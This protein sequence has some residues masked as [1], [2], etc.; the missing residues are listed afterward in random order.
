MNFELA[1]RRS[2]LNGA[3]QHI[4][5]LATETQHQISQGCDVPL[6]LIAYYGTGRL[7]VHK[8]SSSARQDNHQIGSRLQ[9]FCLTGAGLDDWLVNI[10]RWL[11]NL[12]LLPVIL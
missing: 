1:V 6:P 3:A 11:V 9:P 2:L 8:R 7:W 10:D 12:P 4:R 5:A